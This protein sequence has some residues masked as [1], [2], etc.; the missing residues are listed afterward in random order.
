MADTK[1]KLKMPRWVLRGLLIGFILGI[2]LYLIG[3]VAVAVSPF[4]PANV[5]LVAGALGFI[6][7]M[8]WAFE[9]ELD[10]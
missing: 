6:V 8:G 9:E 7:G 3:G 2:V 10:S 1:T 5:D 4:L